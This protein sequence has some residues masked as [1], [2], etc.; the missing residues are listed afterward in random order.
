MQRFRYPYT[1][2]WIKSVFIQRV[3]RVTRT[4][5]FHQT[6][7]GLTRFSQLG[8]N[9]QM[10]S[11]TR[12]NRRGRRQPIDP[13]LGGADLRG[14]RLDLRLAFGRASRHAGDPIVELFARRP[15]LAFQSGSVGI[16]C[17]DIAN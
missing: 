15:D 7:V 1:A 16:G 10:G 17:A 2:K 6:Y 14:Q 9:V 13:F 12:G 3:E 8:P 4:L 11:D 5:N